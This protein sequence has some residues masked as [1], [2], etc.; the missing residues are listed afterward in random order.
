MEKDPPYHSIKPTMDPKQVSR[1]LENCIQLGN[2]IL[3]EDA[4]EVFDPLLDPL[5]SK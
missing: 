4:T 5:I 3:F 1:V 2:P